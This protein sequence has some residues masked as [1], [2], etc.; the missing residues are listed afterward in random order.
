LLGFESRRGHGCL[1]SVSVVC[2]IRLRS[3]RR[4][5]H[6][7]SGVLVSVVSFECD[8]TASI[9]RRPGP[10]GVVASWGKEINLFIQ[11][12][13][14]GTHKSTGRYTGCDREH[15]TIASVVLTNL[16]FTVP[17][18]ELLGDHGSK[19]RTSCI[20]GYVILENQ[21]CNLQV[22][23]STCKKFLFKTKPNSCLAHG[24]H[25]GA[26]PLKSRS[27]TASLIL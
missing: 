21:N 1:S 23:H 14:R 4:A 8:C 17:I 9:M 19:H 2:V 15:I 3:L 5:I 12:S 6:S 16:K 24:L 7:S 11:T 20:H 26:T 25:S 13:P 18:T 22:A 10:L 27:K